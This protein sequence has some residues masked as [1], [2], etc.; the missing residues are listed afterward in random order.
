MR[1]VYRAVTAP[2]PPALIEA[3]RAR[4][5]DAVLHYSKRSA[6]NFLTGARTAGVEGNALA[7]R[8]VCLSAQVA[9]PLRTAGARDIMVAKHP[10]EAAMFE[11]LTPSGG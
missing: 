7:I 6:D 10:D 4:T 9:E 3:L 5:L 2:L 1:V 11:L 8:H